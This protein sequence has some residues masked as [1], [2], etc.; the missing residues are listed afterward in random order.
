MGGAQAYASLLQ[1][2]LDALVKVTVGEN[3]TQHGGSVPEGYDRVERP[4]TY[5]LKAFC[6][7]AM[8]SDGEL[9]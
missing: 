7:K 5:K 4:S 2:T 6:I 1:A 3:S 9:M 8:Q